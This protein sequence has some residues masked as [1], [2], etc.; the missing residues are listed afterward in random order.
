MTRR[1][2]LPF[3]KFVT[4][5]TLAPGTAPG[6]AVRDIKSLFEPFEKQGIWRRHLRRSE[7]PLLWKPFP[8]PL[9][10]RI[11]GHVLIVKAFKPISTA[12][13]PAVRAA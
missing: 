2:F 8:L 5:E 7:L 1:K 12:L 6:L 9:M 4:P 13:S 3:L 10:E 11:M